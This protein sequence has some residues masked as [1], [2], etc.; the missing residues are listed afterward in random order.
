MQQVI[1][2]ALLYIQ[3]TKMF[4]WLQHNE[5]NEDLKRVHSRKVKLEVKLPRCCARGIIP[6]LIH[7]RE[8]ELDDLQEVDIAPQQ[9]VLVIHCAPK[10]SDRSDNNSGELCVLVNNINKCLF[11][12]TQ[13]SVITHWNKS[14]RAVKA[15]EMS[16]H[17][18]LKDI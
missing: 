14:L 11:F 9:L 18:S 4:R 17:E 6:F 8:P 3:Y 5:N 10:L 13:K 15:K 12:F 7:E 16:S 1:K 2:S